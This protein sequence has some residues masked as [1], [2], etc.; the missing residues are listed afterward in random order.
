[1]TEWGSPEVDLDAYL[2]RVGLGGPAWVARPEPTAATLSELHRAHVLSIPFENIDVTLGAPVDLSV[3]AVERKLVGRRRGG[4][5]HEHNLLFAA[6]LE[7]LGY[8]VRRVLTRVRDDGVV[9]LPRGHSALLVEVAG[10]AWLCDVGY[11]CDG[12]IEP[13]PLSA[14]TVHQGPWSFELSPGEGGW[15]LCT[16]DRTVLYSFTD[17]EYR[18]PDFD[19]A[20]YYLLTHP[21]SPFSTSLVVQRATADARYA[22]RSLDLTVAHPD[23][24]RLTERIGPDDLTD[25]LRGMFGIEIDAPEAEAIA[26]FIEGHRDQAQ[27]PL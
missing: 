26:A 23:G 7:Q 24:R 13:I 27:V 12:I 5:C 6:V 14:S 3:G 10:E 19:V 11:G 18:R 17:A 20:A 1:M 9:L 21:G 25:V 22:L 2:R 4:V 15:R 8:G 16:S